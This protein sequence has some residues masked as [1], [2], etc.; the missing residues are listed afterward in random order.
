MRT[1]PRMP[2]FSFSPT[3][4][5]L[6]HANDNFS[7]DAGTTRLTDWPLARLLAAGKITRQ[8]YDAGEQLAEI[9]H[10]ATISTLGATDYSRPVVDGGGAEGGVVDFRM[11]ASDALRKRVRIMGADGPLAVA[12]ACE[13]AD[14]RAEQL[15]ALRAALG[16]MGGYL[17]I[18]EAA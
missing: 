1:K 9:Y 18:G 14:L 12:V 8:Q 5:R 15:P 17:K 10:S 2:T 13:G 3:P 4:E 6:A 7:T 11:R 16:A